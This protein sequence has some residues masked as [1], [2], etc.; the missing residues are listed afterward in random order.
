MALRPCTLWLLLFFRP[1]GEVRRIHLTRSYTEGATFSIGTLRSAPIRTERSNRPA[2]FHVG[3]NVGN[4]PSN[5]KGFFGQKQAKNRVW[6]R[7]LFREWFREYNPGQ[8]RVGIQQLNLER[9]QEA[10]LEEYPRVFRD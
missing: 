1:L 2:S 9:F 7:G 10:S 6:Y 5:S 3:G 4:L 8:L